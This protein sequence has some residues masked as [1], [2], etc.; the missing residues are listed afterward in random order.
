M[1][2]ILRDDA[3][4]STSDGFALRL[5][6]PW[7]RSLPLASL[8][9][10]AVTIDGV[11]IDRMQAALGTRRVAVSDLEAEPGWWFVQDRLVVHGTTALAP[12]RH[13][14]TVSF[15]LVIPYLSAGPDAPL[16]LPFH[17]ARELDLDAA[18]SVPSVSRDVA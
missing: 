11:Q 5:S 13:A 15:R 18:A 3:L 8:D 4:T 10:L 2:E 16:A 1:L 12:G 9:G 14:V 6:L 7:I 17:A